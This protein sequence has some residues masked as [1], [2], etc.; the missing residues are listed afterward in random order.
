MAEF[1]RDSVLAKQ[2]RVIIVDL[3][4]SVFD[5]PADC[6]S[7]FKPGGE[8]H[9]LLEKKHGIIDVIDTLHKSHSELHGKPSRKTR[10]TEDMTYWFVG[11]RSYR[12][13]VCLIFPSIYFGS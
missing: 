2:L 1:D 13:V 4:I 8:L 7:K 5:L 10:S 9:H 3:F 6:L 12:K 11:Y